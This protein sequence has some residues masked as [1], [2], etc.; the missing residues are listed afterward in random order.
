ME[1]EFEKVYEEFKG[2]RPMYKSLKCIGTGIPRW[3]LHIL[4]KGTAPMGGDMELI[5]VERPTRDE[6]L[7]SGIEAM[8]KRMNS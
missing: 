4:E 7:R 3:R 6:C 8:R 2:S 1:Q 5:F